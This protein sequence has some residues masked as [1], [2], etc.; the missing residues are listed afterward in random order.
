VKISVLEERSA[1]VGFP[2]SAERGTEEDLEKVF[3]Y[4]VFLVTNQSINR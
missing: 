1:T 2:P 3:A 4:Y